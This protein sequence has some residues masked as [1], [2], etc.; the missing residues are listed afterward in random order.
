MALTCSFPY[1]QVCAC[2]VLSETNRVKDIHDYAASGP[3]PLQFSVPE[4]I[5]LHANRIRFAYRPLRWFL[6][7]LVIIDDWESIDVH[8][9]FAFEAHTVLF[10]DMLH[11]V[12]IVLK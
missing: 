8:R 5:F 3:A 7:Q 10:I 4:H 12:D 11:Y 2:A 9:F 6:A 1:L